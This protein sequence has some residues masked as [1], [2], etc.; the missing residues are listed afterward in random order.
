MAALCLCHWGVPKPAVFSMINMIN[1]LNHHIQYVYGN[2]QHSTNQKQWGNPIVGIGQGNGAGPQIWAAVSFPLF[3][4]MPQD[5]FLAMVHC[6]MSVLWEDIVG[7]TFVNDTDLCTSSPTRDDSI[8]IQMQQLVTNWEG[9][10]LHVTRGAL[11]Q[12]K[13]FWYLIDQQWD[14]DH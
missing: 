6:T 3:D 9:L 2:S 1:G 5:G 12:D 11:V 8:V 4:I 10:L 14:K 13:C 7:F